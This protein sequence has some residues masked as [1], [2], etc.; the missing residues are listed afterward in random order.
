M[1]QLGANEQSKANN[2][3]E[4]YCKI[5]NKQNFFIG[6]VNREQFIAGV[7]RSIPPNELDELLKFEIIPSHLLDEVN[8]V[9]SLSSSTT[10][11]RNTNDYGSYDVVTDDQL[12]QIANQASHKSWPK[13]ALALGFLEYDIEAYKIRNNNDAAATVS[14][15]FIL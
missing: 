12:K 7:R 1:H 9:Q 13:L 8:A 6:K 15:I 14:L 10:N 3:N 11:V 2:Q 5:K 4:N